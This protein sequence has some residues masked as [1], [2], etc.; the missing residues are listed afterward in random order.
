MHRED[1]EYYYKKIENKLTEL[2]AIKTLISN[3]YYSEE[4]FWKIWNKEN[5]DIVKKKVDSDNIFRDL[6]EKTCRAS[7][8]LD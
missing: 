1:K 5:Y 8:G 6:Y 4:E 7:R 2:G 3:N